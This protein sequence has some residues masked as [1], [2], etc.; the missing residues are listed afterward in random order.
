MWLMG[1]LADAARGAG[2]TLLV[3]YIPRLERG[4]ATPPP[5][6][7]ASAT[8]EHGVMLADLTPRVLQY[9]ANERHPP[10]ILA[11]DGHPNAAA[12]ALIADELERT[13][14]SHKLLE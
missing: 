7:L 13:L 12:H 5:E 6:A 4:N 10:L 8:K 11:H 1:Q 3:A 14:R 9:Y 2:A